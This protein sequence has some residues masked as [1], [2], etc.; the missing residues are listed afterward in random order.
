MI[1]C[2]SFLYLIAYKNQWQCSAHCNCL[3]C[4]SPTGS[5]FSNYIEND[6]LAKM[7]KLDDTV[8]ELCQ[9]FVI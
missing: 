1:D 7:R 9:K 6:F 3:G 4:A 2:L 8:H 5:Q